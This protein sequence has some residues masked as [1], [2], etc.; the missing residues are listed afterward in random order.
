MHG[1]CL[2]E[3]FCYSTPVI[4][5]ISHFHFLQTDLDCMQ[6]PAAI[7]R[8]LQAAIPVLPP[9]LP[10]SISCQPPLLSS[11]ALASMQ[12]SLASPGFQA[13]N[14][15]LPQRSP[16]PSAR[17]SSNASAK[18]RP[19]QSQDPDV[20][21]DP[22]MLLEDGTGSVPVS[23]NSNVSVGS[24][25]ANLKACSWLKGAIRVRRTDLTYIGTVDDDSWFLLFKFII[26]SWWQWWLLPF[27]TDEISTLLEFEFFSEWGAM[28]RFFLGVVLK[29]EHSCVMSSIPSL[30]VPRPRDARSATN[31]WNTLVSLHPFPV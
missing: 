20:E 23:G 29:L 7:R 9:S 25:H 26:G 11:A 30:A 12:S 24:D 15:N 6:L 21:I 5:V 1:I 31:P 8:R 3:G 27:T 22:W 13:G 18:S 17:T 4:L 19:L 2:G 28:G 10:P 14:S 16:I